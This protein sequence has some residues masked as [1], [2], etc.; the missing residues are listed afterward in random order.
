[1]ADPTLTIQQMVEQYQAG[2]LAREADAMARLV[3]SY[4][5]VYTQLTAQADALIAEVAALRAQG[6]EPSRAQ[7]RKM[8]R[9]KSLMDQ[10]ARQLERYGAVVED[11]TRG[12]QL[13]AAR[14]ANQ[15]VEQLVLGMLDGWPAETRGSIMATF[16][17]LPNDAIVA[18]IGA[19][20]EGSPLVT[21]TF[22]RFGYDVATQMGA[23]LVQGLASGVGPRK[24]AADMRR[25]LGVPLTDALRIARTE[26]NRAFRTASLADYRA[27]AHIVTGWIWYASLDERTCGSCIAMHGTEHPLSEELDDHP[28]GRCTMVPT[29]VSPRDIGI[30]IP[31]EPLEVESGEDWFNAQSEATQRGILGDAK[32][33]AWAAG[34]FPF[35]A[36]STQSSDPR[37][38]TMRTETP[39]KDL[40]G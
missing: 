27:N 4:G 24:L 35:S 2:V 38:G 1:M 31:W 14:A 23:V 9:Y 32:Y 18:L 40:V 20:T 33:D 12:A 26:T 34:K 15:G 22:A 8:A 29:T 37:W 36:L 6:Q 13:D 39:L 25:I 5:R 21:E 10:T 28:N 19:M 3:E 16:Q 17:V 30:D 7:I 11:E